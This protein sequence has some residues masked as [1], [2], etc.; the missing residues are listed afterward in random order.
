MDMTS[1]GADVA[2]VPTE[3]AILQLWKEAASNPGVSFKGVTCR[4]DSESTV[5]V[6]LPTNMDSKRQVLEYLQQQ[7]SMDFLRHHG[8][9][10]S[11]DVIL[12]KTNKKKLM[13]IW[14]VWNAEHATS[15]T[16]INR[17]EKLASIF[18]EMLKPVNSNVNKVVAGILHESSDSEL[19]C[20]GVKEYNNRTPNLQVCLF[21]GAVRDMHPWENCVLEPCCSEVRVPLVRVR[22]GSVS[23]FTSK[24]LSVLAHHDAHGKLRPAILELCDDNHEVKKKDSNDQDDTLTITPGTQRLHV[25]C[26]L[27]LSSDALTSELVN[28]SRALWALVR[29]VVCTLWRSRLASNAKGMC[30]LQNTLT[31]V[32]EDGLAV[33][34]QQDE[35]VGSLAV[36]HQAAPCEYQILQAL[37]KKRDDAPI[38]WNQERADALLETVMDGQHIV[39][40]YALDLQGEHTSNN[41]LSTMYSLKK[42]ATDVQMGQLVALLR[43]RNDNGDSV[44]HNHQG[45]KLMCRACKRR[46][47]QV[48][49][50]SIVT[51]P[52]QD[53]EGATVTMLQHFIY[54]GRLF[55]ALNQLSS[56]K[57]K[58]DKK[59]RQKRHKNARKEQKKRK[60]KQ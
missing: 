34:L 20:F 9:N 24:I 15:T 5:G 39:P 11:A 8:L 55:A 52:V 2:V 1:S 35:L 57:L 54:Q 7:C 58:D 14:R 50:E 25:V 6:S 32:F 17:Q 30:P 22:L 46:G 18:Q 23:E 4:R 21:L 38:E 47:I 45:N 44:P 37:C 29:V 33:T 40:T 60:T 16:S 31:I 13:E 56:S 41:L 12:R 53:K 27:P 10:S 43:I 3:Q 42:K 49:C 48:V 59:G 28:R 19:P 51:S 36:Q 26:S